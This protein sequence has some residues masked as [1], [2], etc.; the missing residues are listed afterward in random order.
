M[1][2]ILACHHLKLWRHHLWLYPK[3]PRDTAFYTTITALIDLYTR[4]LQDDELVLSVDEK[5][6]LS[7]ASHAAR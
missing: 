7:S 1:R 4:P 2:R 6:A 5:T 3:K